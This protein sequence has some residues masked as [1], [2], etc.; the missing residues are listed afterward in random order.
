MSHVRSFLFLAFR[1]VTHICFFLLKLT[2]SH[3]VLILGSAK[4]SKIRSSFPG[5]SVQMV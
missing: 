5:S 1:Y 2:S 4:N 3:Y